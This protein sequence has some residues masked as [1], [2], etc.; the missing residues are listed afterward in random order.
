MCR[1]VLYHALVIALLFSV[2]SFELCLSHFVVLHKGI[3]VV[4]V[5]V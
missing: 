2:L 4:L 1:V 3:V 5:L